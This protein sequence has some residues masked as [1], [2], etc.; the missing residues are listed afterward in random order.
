RVGYTAGSTGRHRGL[1]TFRPHRASDS[2]IALEALHDEGY[3]QQRGVDRGALL[4]RVTLL[5]SARLGVTQLLGAAAL[6]RFE[7]PGTLRAEDVEAGRVGFYDSYD[8]AGRGESGRAL[9][10]LSHRWQRGGQR[11]E[12]RVYGGYRALRLL[13]NYTGALYERVHGDRRQQ[14][15]EAL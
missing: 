10:A 13:E 9:L 11:L 15:Q 7:L 8:H 3:G 14:R 4:G 12:A 5:D 6:S 1:F 2:F